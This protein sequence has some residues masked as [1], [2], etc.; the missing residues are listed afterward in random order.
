MR[1]FVWA[2]GSVVLT[3]AAAAQETP[4][5]PERL[6]R[7][8]EPLEIVIRADFKELFKDRDTLTDRPVEGTLSLVDERRGALTLPIQLET[9]GH[10]RL[11]RTTCPFPPLKVRFD[12]DSAKGSVF[13][14]QGS[15]KLATHCR[16]SSR[17]EQN[18]LVE[19]GVYRMY[20]LLT[21]LSHRT[22]LARVR[23]VPLP[24][25][26]NAETHY[27]FF[28]E[29]DDEMAR[30]NSGKLLMQTGGTFSHMDPP[31]LD[32]M[33]VF[34]YMIGNT[35]WSVFMIHNVRL[36]DLGMNREYLPVAYDFDFSGLVDAP[37]AV[38][39]QR[40]PIRSVRTRLFRGPCRK[41]EEIA[42]TLARFAGARDSLVAELAS[43]PGL[44]PKRL[45]AATD[46]LDD[47]FKDAAN[48]KSF[49]DALG[50]ACR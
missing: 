20:N 47:F 6:F 19:E 5:Q 33:S 24:D 16:N 36:V 28:I 18:L 11:K 27:G 35:D 34:E 43:V 14:G 44:E 31:L 38:P 50:Y 32:L 10:F 26:A 29:D 12:K 2:V 9:R 49:D 21:P 30:R 46:Y 39:D 42:P 22:R 25:S 45:R 3:A 8:R 41:R 4:R 7:S 40:L 15:I 1:P 23:Y 37:Y 13:G 17:H 48:P